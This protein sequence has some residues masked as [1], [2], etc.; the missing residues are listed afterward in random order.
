VIGAGTFLAGAQSRLLP[1]SVPFRFFAAAGIYHIVFW[2][3]LALAADDLISYR[4][5][6]G[7]P[8]AAIHLLT[9]GVL[10]MTA[11]GASLQLL[12]VATRRPVG[13]LWP[14]RAIFWLLTL[15]VGLLTYGMT[16]LEPMALDSGGVLVVAALGLYAV[17]IAQNLRGTK[18]FRVVVLHGWLAIG[19]LFVLATLGLLLVADFYRGF[20]TDRTAFAALHLAVAGYGFMGSLAIGFSFVLVPMFALASEM[21]ERRGL[22]SFALSMTALILASVGIIVNLG[23]L[24]AVAA[25]IGLAGAGFYLAAM[26]KILNSG[27]RKRLG[28][29]FALVRAAWVSLPLSLVLGLAL[30]LDL[31]PEGGDALFGLILLAGWLLTFLL[32]I[33]QRIAPFLVSMHSTAG[34]GQAARPSDLTAELPLKIHAACHTAAILILVVG[35]L[36]QSGAMARLGALIGV[37]GALS[38]AVFLAGVPIRLAAHTRR[39][40]RASQENS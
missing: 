27:M 14:V 40:R 18:G 25:A 4:G 10:T 1:L 13:A 20:L 21:A 39:F 2:V 23:W 28:L 8:L 24:T 34:G 3:I 29:S 38:F 33:L 6:P 11:I 19:A 26:T 32:G 35:F 15:G 5:G 37:A 16:T 17:L 31:L 30:A 7:L 9:L 22:A 12:P 36:G